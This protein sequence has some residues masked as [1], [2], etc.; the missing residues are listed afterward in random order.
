MRIRL[1]TGPGCGLCDQAKE[2]IYPLLSK[3]ISLEE[4]DVT[5]NLENKKKYGLRIPVLVRP[6]GEELDWPFDFKTLESFLSSS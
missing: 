1:Y 3:D 4:V 5:L 2:L 6:G